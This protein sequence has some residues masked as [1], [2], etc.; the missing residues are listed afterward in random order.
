[1]QEAH[2]YCKPPISTDGT[3]LL[4]GAA[5]PPST[6]GSVTVMKE[7]LQHF[8]PHSYNVVTLRHLKDSGDKEFEQRTMRLGLRRFRPYN[9]ALWIRFLQTPFIVRAACS[10]ARRVGA[11]KIICIFPTI[12]FLFLGYLMAK[13]TGL[14][15]ILYLHDTI[16]EALSKSTFAIPSKWIQ[17]LAFKRAASIM[18]ISDG[19][20]DFYKM[21]YKLDT[22]S[23]PHTYQEKIP[24]LNELLPIDT[25]RLFWG[26]AVYGIN[27]IALRRVVATAKILNM[28]FRF[29]TRA[30]DALLRNLSEPSDSKTIETVY[31]D[32]REEYLAALPLN[33]I[34]VLALNYP[35]EAGFGADEVATIFPTKTPEY[36]AAGTLIIVHC[37]ED[38]FLARFF[39]EHSCGLVIS[40]RDPTI[41][42]GKIKALMGNLDSVNQMRGN[43]LKAAHRFLPHRICDIFSRAVTNA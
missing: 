23:V 10:Y 21:R 28:T 26:G 32:A 9:L 8:D 14:P 39:K 42:A 3:V 11:R 36:L 31:Y 16:S 30:R 15:L 37:P 27:E 17:R 12:D 19:M 13:K 4:V 18:V 5:F 34:M 33:G 40:D 20:R 24:A 2:R 29:T 43:A 7:L 38:Y 25:N 35:E 6:G 22:V 1:M 41:M